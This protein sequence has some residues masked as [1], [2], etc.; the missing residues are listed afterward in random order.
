MDNM[1]TAAKAAMNKHGPK[2][3]MNVNL[4]RCKM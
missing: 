1:D 4:S 3:K 2:T